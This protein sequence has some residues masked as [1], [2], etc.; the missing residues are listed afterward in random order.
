MSVDQT[1]H[2]VKPQNTTLDAF[3]GGR[4]QLL[5]PEKGF[6]AGSDSVL[7]GASVPADARRIV[8]LGAGIGTA[9]LVV[10]C[11]TTA[12][13]VVLAERD[14]GALALARRN[15]ETNGFAERVTVAEIDISAGGPARAA[16]GLAPNRFDCVIAN[17][18]FFEKGRG[19]PAD[20]PDRDAARHDEADGIDK[21]V[22]VA[23]GLAAPRGMAIFILPAARLGVALAAFEKRFGD[24]RILPIAARP[25]TEAGR[26]LIAGVKGS[27]APLRLFA[28]LVLHGE[29]G[30]D[31]VS[32]AREVLT[33]RHKLDW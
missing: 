19:T 3:L 7:L 20:A 13:E 28:P 18:P 29:T 9:G 16:A 27:R 12:A 25:G 4:L 22:R 30:N 5:Q 15:V 21:W 24:V 6:R 2:F 31:F 26:I 10:A 23:A 11:W 17:P 14:A 8:D 1:S 32:P 33:G